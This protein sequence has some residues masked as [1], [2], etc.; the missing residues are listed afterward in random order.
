MATLYRPT[1]T[2]FVDKNG[3]RVPKGTPGAKR[4]REKSQTWRARYKDASG[5]V[6]TVSLLDDKDLSEAK[7]AAILQRVREEKAGIRKFDPFEEHRETPL[8]CPK[9]S[10]EGCVNDKGR[11]IACATNHLDAFQDHLSAK[12]GTERHVV[13]TLR[14]IRHAF[15]SC[16]FKSLLDLDG[17][18]VSTWLRDCRKTGMG[19][20]TSNHYLTAVKSFGNWLLKARRL[21]ENPFAHVSR[22][23]AKIDV[24]V[25][26]RALTQDEL[27]WLVSAAETGDEFRGL[28]G[29]DRAVL[30]LMAAFTGLRA[31]ELFSLTE[32]SLDFSRDPPTV[33]VEAAYSKHRRQDVLPLH[34]DLA[35]KLKAWLQKRRAAVTDLGILRFPESESVAESDAAKIPSPTDPLFP[36]TWTERA[37]DM[38]KADLDSARKAWIKEAQRPEER[39][40]RGKSP[41][42]QFETEA[43][44]ADFHALR[45][46]FI[47]GLANSGVHPKLAKELARHS[48][49]TL[50]M[51]RYAHV[52]LLDMNSALKSLP[53]LP[54]RKRE[55][56]RS[57]RTGTG[58]DLVAPM[59]APETVQPKRCQEISEVPAEWEGDAGDDS[60]VMPNN[61]LCES[62]IAS[63]NWGRR[64]SNPEPTDYESGTES[65][66]GADVIGDCGDGE[67]L[68]APM[69]AL[70]TPE[71]GCK[72]LSS[73]D[74]LDD[75]FR[76]LPTD[77]ASVVRAW[78]SLP[79]SLRS[80]VLAIVGTAAG[81][82]TGSGS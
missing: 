74:N 8:F 82:E 48:T 25:V 46:T 21:P 4:I 27:S 5:K 10:G 20:G 17:G 56:Q 6:R 78:P 53:D 50:T 72:P 58:P 31:S 42:L 37:A 40:K 61:D 44:R 24:R 9:C 14:R 1:I 80:A 34:P 41:F 59:V 65:S 16:G 45:H 7:L 68:V 77:L 33:T 12:G 47:T 81:G 49:I 69:V 22:V 54:Q 36:G 62:V 73:P 13:Q 66:Q 76:L 2:R 29:K 28:A 23:N 70:G 3:N 51:D 32:Q 63:D 43:G 38:M 30:Y 39:K 67:N 35:T 18:K 55:Q 15:T 52:G 79:D 71:N 64:D 57:I 11:S 60:K 19:S 75:L 26:R